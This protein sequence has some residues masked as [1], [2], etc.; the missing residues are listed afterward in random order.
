MRYAFV[1]AERTQY[2]VQVLCRVMEVSTSG[3]YDYTHRQPRPDPDA[4]IRIALR[5][6]YAASR[7]TYGRPR[8]VAALRQKS[9]AVG[10]KRVRRLMREE[11]IQG[12]S[13]GGF[14][15]CTTDSCHYLPVASNVLARQFSID[16]PTPTWVSDITYLPTREGWLYL[17]IVLSIQ[18]RQILGYS[19]SDRMPDGLVE[20]AFLNAWSAC[21]GSSRAVFHSDQGRQYAS[22]KFRLTLAKK[23]FTQSMS[24]KGN[25]WDNAVAESFF[26]T[27]KREEAFGVY[28]TKKQ[29]QLSIAS[30]VHGFYNSSR[31]HS[32]LGY[33]SPNEYAKSLRQKTG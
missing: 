7:K 26:A 28:P 31:L 25:C 14:R 20:S 9:F 23:D 6:A 10:H 2:P 11:R 24:R 3:F 12:K 5:S 16:N 21:S 19:L 30:Y 4:Q 15:P 1:A 17:A 33:R 8:L 22:S 18:T 32:A 27:L 29:A 13:K